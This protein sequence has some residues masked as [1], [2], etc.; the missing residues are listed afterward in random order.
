MSVPV[1]AGISFSIP[2]T[3]IEVIAWAINKLLSTILVHADVRDKNIE[4]MTLSGVCMNG[5]RW[6]QKVV[7][8]APISRQQD[9]LDYLLIKFK[10]L[11]L[12]NSVEEL[13]LSVDVLG[14]EYAIQK[15]LFAVQDDST[16]NLRRS[17]QKIKIITFTHILLTIISI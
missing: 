14:V 11:T 15:T 8:K 2:V 13:S 3:N 17:I 6:H 12:P 4:K 9:F 5:Y 7:F 1:D 16:A 10:M